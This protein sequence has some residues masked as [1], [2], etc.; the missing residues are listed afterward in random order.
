MCGYNE[1]G[2]TPPHPHFGSSNGASAPTGEPAILGRP[3]REVEPGSNEP[4]TRASL[5]LTHC[6]PLL[7]AG[8]FGGR[9]KSR[10]VNHREQI[11]TTK[12]FGI[13]RQE[14]SASPIHRVALVGGDGRTPSSSPVGV[15]L[16]LFAGSRDGGN[17]DQRA[18]R[19][20]IRAGSVDLVLVLSRFFSH[21]DFRCLKRL[22]RRRGIPLRV[23]RGSSLP[24]NLKVS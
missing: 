11:M 21:S 20:A 13:P 1:C 17:G 18:L 19:A 2:A 8:L 16:R 15:E 22:C 10:P 3:V 5:D 4:S 7:W 12:P 14:S 6:V 23:L 9:W 24:S